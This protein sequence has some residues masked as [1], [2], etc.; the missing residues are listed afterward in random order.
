MTYVQDSA[1]QVRTKRMDH[2]YEYLSMNQGR[3]H[4]KNDA[5]ISKVGEDDHVDKKCSP[6]KY[7]NS[8]S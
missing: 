5:P 4:G 3:R 8:D 1:L 7:G 2:S 6:H